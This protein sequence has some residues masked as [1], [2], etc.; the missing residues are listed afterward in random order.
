MGPC[1]FVVFAVLSMSP[2]LVYGEQSVC[3]GVQIRGPNCGPTVW[4][5]DHHMKD[6]TLIVRMH[7]AFNTID[8][9]NHHF[10]RFLIQGPV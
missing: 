6:S 2:C 5:A 10:C 8:Y 3:I 7:K 4:I 1:S 9:H